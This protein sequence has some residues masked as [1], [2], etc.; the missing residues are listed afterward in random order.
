[1]PGFYDFFWYYIIFGVIGWVMESTLVSIQ[2][3][4][5]VNRGFLSG[6]IC[7]IYGTAMCLIILA[8]TP[9]RLFAFRDDASFWRG[10]VVMLVISELIACAVEYFVGW[11]L[12][13]MYDQR[14][15]D[16]SDHRF[17]LNG[18]IAIP[19][20]LAWGPLAAAA[21]LWLVPWLDGL[22]AKIPP[23]VGWMILAVIGASMLADYLRILHKMSMLD[24][25]AA[26]IAAGHAE[27]RARLAERRK[28]ER[29]LWRR[30]RGAYPQLVEKW[31]GKSKIA[32]EVLKND[33]E[34]SEKE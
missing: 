20:S 32:E 28:R 33:E 7:P 13:K 22:I 2:Q 6:P 31:F 10:L 18:R 1:M 11:L 8:L 15:W 23:T 34:T 9:V 3:K 25:L 19:E 12:E 17:N 29:R 5:F 27:L 24:K 14:W 21:V 30:M 26:Q 16:Y 4:K